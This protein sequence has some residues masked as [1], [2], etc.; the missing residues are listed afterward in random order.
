MFIRTYHPSLCLF[1]LGPCFLI[2]KSWHQKHFEGSG[3]GYWPSF[4]WHVVGWGWKIQ[5]GKDDSGLSRL[6]C[7]VQGEGFRVAPRLR[8]AEVGLDA[9]VGTWVQVV[10][11]C[12]DLYFIKWTLIPLTGPRGVYAAKFKS[13][14]EIGPF[15]SRGRYDSPCMALVFLSLLVCTTENLYSLGTKPEKAYEGLQTLKDRWWTNLP[16]F[17][18]CQKLQLIRMFLSQ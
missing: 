2:L 16:S 18:V 4:F 1:I 15:N 9:D 5:K 8:A 11:P 14:I 6:L 7:K 17:R 12:I 3:P 10:Q 13:P